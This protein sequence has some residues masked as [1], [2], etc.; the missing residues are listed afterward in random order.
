[1]NLARL[2]TESAHNDLVKED[3]TSLLCEAGIWDDIADWDF[4][5]ADQSLIVTLLPSS[6]PDF[7]DDQLTLLGKAGFK[8]LHVPGYGPLSSFCLTQP[9]VEA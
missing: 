7:T 2:L 8:H 5:E 9:K 4:C 3:V 6:T 1:M